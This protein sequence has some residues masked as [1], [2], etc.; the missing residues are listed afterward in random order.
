[1]RESRIRAQAMDY[2]V[3]IL[4]VVEKLKERNETI[5]SVQLGASGVSIGAVINKSQAPDCETEEQL[6]LLQEAMKAI[7]ETGYWVEL[8]HRA[9]YLSD[10][11]YQLL[12]SD[13]TALRVSV[14]TA[15]RQARQL[16][17]QDVSGDRQA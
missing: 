10:S 5:V 16:M 1:M 4:R 3:S 11:D 6:E 17:A 15:I 12:D 9:D 2:A 14:L 8:L 7:D 13:R